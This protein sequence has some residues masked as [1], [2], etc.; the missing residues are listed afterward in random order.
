MRSTQANAAY[1]NTCGLPP[2]HV[3]LPSGN[4]TGTWVL[5]EEA[6]QFGPMG[7]GFSFPRL[8][9]THQG[10][11]LTVQSTSPRIQG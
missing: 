1:R 7:A 8:V 5:N 9:V 10:N 2:A 6:S 3:A 11:V 4:F